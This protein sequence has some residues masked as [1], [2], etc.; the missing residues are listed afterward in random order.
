M[1]YAFYKK[2]NNLILTHPI[3][4]RQH[5]LNLEPSIG[6]EFCK[7]IFDTWTTSQNSPKL[8]T[9]YYEPKIGTGKRHFEFEITQKGQEEYSTD[10]LRRMIIGYHIAFNRSRKFIE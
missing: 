1:S 4:I 2:L 8:L 5:H 10:E 7:P 3:G 6:S 9:D